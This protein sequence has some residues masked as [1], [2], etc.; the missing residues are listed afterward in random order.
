M[1][2]PLLDLQALRSLATG[3]DLASFAKAADQLGRSTSAI[4]A[5][6]KKLEDQ[7]G[8][9]LLQKDGRGLVPTP[10]GEVLLGYARRLLELNDEAVHAARGARLSGEVRLGV[11]EDFGERL[12]PGVLGAFARAHPQ[13]L[14]ETRLARNSEL[15]RDIEQRRL[16]LALAWDA[17]P[18]DPA[19]RRLGQLPMCWI[20]PARSDWPARAGA[21]SLPLVALESPC[22]MRRAAVQALD[23]AGIPWRLAFTSSSLAGTWAAVAAGLGVT[24]RTTAGIPAGLAVLD[25]L[26]PLP[27]IGLTVYR[28]QAQPAPAVRQLEALLVDHVQSYDLVPEAAPSV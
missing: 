17:G 23:A 14:I 18:T 6:L 2:Q 21:A 24:V 7:V 5:Q 28:A 10:A 20:G 26:P 19:H 25:G 16:D 22:L 12:L 1:H 9:R 27:S 3:V 4:S 11:Q 15:L 13:V 8:E